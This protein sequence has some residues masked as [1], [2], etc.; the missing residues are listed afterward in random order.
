MPRPDDLIQRV[1]GAAIF[2]SM[3]IKSAFWKVPVHPEDKEKTAFVT[4]DGLFQFI[5][6]PFG[7]CNSSA[8]FVRIIDLALLNLK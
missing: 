4:T 8:T 5:Y 3:D 2:S 1:V 7:L 6:L